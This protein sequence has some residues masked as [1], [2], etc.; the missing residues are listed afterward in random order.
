[1]SPKNLVEEAGT[2]GLHQQLLCDIF[3][4]FRRTMGYDKLLEEAG[5]FGLYQQLL[6]GILVFY[7]TFLCAINYYT[8]VNRKLLLRGLNS[9]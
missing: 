7:T 8:Q 5:S 9:V 4:F 6:C 1:M 2:Y 3:M